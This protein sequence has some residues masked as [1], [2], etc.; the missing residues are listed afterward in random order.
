MILDFEVRVKYDEDNLR[1]SSDEDNL[2]RAS[3]ALRRGG[4]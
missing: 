1:R 2:R 3:V 4:C